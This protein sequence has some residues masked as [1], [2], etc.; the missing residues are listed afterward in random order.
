MRKLSFKT[1]PCIVVVDPF[2][3]GMM[4]A[5]LLQDRGY[6][7]IRVYSSKFPDEVLDTVPKNIEPVTWHA[8]IQ[9]EGGKTSAEALSQTM[10]KIKAVKGVYIE[11]FMVGCETGVELCDEL[12]ERWVQENPGT[13]VTT[14]GTRMS[15]ARRDKYDMGEAVR[16]AGVRSVGQIEVEDGKFEEVLEFVNKVKDPKTGEF[17]VVLKPAMSAGSEG[18]F[19][20]TTEAEC[21]KFFDE[22][23]GATNVFGEINDK[24]L[25]QEFLAGKEYV[26]DSVSVNGVHKTVAIWEYDKRATN[27]AQFV[28]YGMR[29]YES[30]DGSREDILVKYMHS[31]LDAL[32]VKHGPSHGE[33][34]FTST[35]PCLVEVGCRP[36]GGDGTFVKLADK[37][38][39]YNQLSVMVDAH[40]NWSKFSNMP[41]R[42]KKLKW[43]AMEVCLVN[44]Q[45][46]RLVGFPRLPEVEALPSFLEAEIKVKVGANIPLTIDFLTSPG[47]IMLGHES[48][49]QVEKDMEFI[50]KIENEGLMQ[51]SSRARIG[52]L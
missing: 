51:I 39:G 41:S 17:R 20:A 7:V 2:S 49:E 30:E 29:L 35:G 45:E 18:V 34:M 8:S 40:E 43:H 37:P 11:N 25:V 24:V 15:I 6:A 12:T 32:D 31:V 1:P 22:I 50:H 36:H 44:R 52:S 3:S 13:H 14:N 23:Y 4:L 28:Y 26:V 42:P 27:G 47:A 5:R 38:I 33:V 16:L 9:H 19:F 10:R 21:R 46:G 48:W